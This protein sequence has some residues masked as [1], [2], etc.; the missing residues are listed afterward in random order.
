MEV[1]MTLTEFK[2]LSEIAEGYACPH[3]VLG[4]LL[5]KGFVKFSPGGPVVLTAKGLAELKSASAGGFHQ[6]VMMAAFGL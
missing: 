4:K 6:A 5:K 3:E 2:A 1:P